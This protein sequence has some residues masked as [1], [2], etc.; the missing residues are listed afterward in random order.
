MSGWISLQWNRTP[1]MTSEVS[2]GNL[3]LETG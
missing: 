3:E 1:P 2:S